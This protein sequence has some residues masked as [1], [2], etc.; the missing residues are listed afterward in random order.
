MVFPGYN[1][2]VV[3]RETKYSLP[4][5]LQEDFANLALGYETHKCEDC[6][7]LPCLLLFLP[8]LTVPDS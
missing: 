5:P 6:M 8:I 7:C 4:G 1:G 3:E 2:G